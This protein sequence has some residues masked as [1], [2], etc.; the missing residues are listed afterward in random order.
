MAEQG[1][2]HPRRKQRLHT[3]SHERAAQIEC[4]PQ[5]ADRKRVRRRWRFFV[6]MWAVVA[7][8]VATTIRLSAVHD[9]YVLVYRP[10]SRNA[11]NRNQS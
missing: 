9:M 6:V 11:T 3:L 1:Q 4:H 2:K 8:T 10:F 5:C 7:T